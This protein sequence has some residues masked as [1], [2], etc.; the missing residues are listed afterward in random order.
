VCETINL[1][2]DRLILSAWPRTREENQVRK[3][4]FMALI[5]RRNEAARHFSAR[6]SG[7]G[8]DCTGIRGVW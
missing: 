4:Q 7:A 5:E 2:V 3:I 6:P 8:S 1:E